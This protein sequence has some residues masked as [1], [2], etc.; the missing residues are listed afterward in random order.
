MESN[1]MTAAMDDQIN[2]NSTHDLSGSLL[3]GVIEARRRR[4]SVPAQA[5]H[6]PEIAEVVV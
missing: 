3:C 1:M 6:L 4:A 5:V 2:R